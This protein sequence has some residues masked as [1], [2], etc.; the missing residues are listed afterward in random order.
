MNPFVKTTEE[1]AYF[2]KDQLIAHV[3]WLY[4]YIEEIKKELRDAKI[5][6]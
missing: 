5:K 4:R 6:V 3:M 2:D 1:L